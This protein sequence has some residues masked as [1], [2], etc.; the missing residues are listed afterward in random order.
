MK[1]RTLPSPYQSLGLPSYKKIQS[2]KGDVA[3]PPLQKPVLQN[4]KEDPGYGQTSNYEAALA[5]CTGV[6]QDLP[7]VHCAR[8]FGRWTLCVVVPGQL[9]GSCSNCHV[10]GDGSRCSFHA[11]KFFFTAWIF[12][13]QLKISCKNKIRPETNNFIDALTLPSRKHTRGISVSGSGVVSSRSGGVHALLSP[14]SV[15][16]TE[17]KRLKSLDPRSREEERLLATQTINIVERLAFEEDKGDDVEG[18]DE[19]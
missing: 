2:H 16:K 15:Y 11:S 6:V 9:Q 13:L 1:T 19:E 18:V 12:G 10:S 4:D 7:C 3:T 5:Q 14:V 17:Y 8:G